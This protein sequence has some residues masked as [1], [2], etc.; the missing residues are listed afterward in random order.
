[1]GTTKNFATRSRLLSVIENT[2]D[3]IVI[4]DQ[5]GK[6]IFWN[7]ASSKIF[8]YGMKEALDKDLTLIMPKEMHSLHEAG[9]HHYLATGEKKL[10][11]Q[12]VSIDAQKKDGSIFPIELS[13]SAWK[14]E[15]ATFVCGIIR[16]VSNRKKNEQEI[17]DLRGIID[18]SPSCVKLVRRNGE[19]LRMNDVGL[20]LIEANDFESVNRANVYDIIHEE[21]RQRYKEFN[22]FICGGNKGSLIFK[23][24][25]LKGTVRI[26]ESFAR[27][28]RLISGEITHLAITNEITERV[29]AEKDLFEK[30][31]KLE[32]A[33]RLSVIGE[34]AAGIAHE[35]NN[36]LAVI[37]SK[38]QLLELQLN[39]LNLC[40][41]EKE[42]ILK[43]ISIIKST[44]MY[45]TDLIKNL[46]TFSSKADFNNLE[47]IRLEE[48]VQTALKL[49]Q[50]RCTDAGI[51]INLDIDKDLKLVCSAS[52]LSQVILNLMI[53]AIDAL[54]QLENKWIRIRTKVVN[55][56][57]KIIFTDSGSGIPDKITKKIM[58]PF[59]S[60]KEPGKGTGLGLSISLKY[61]EKMNGLF[62]YNPHSSNTEFVI[63]FKTFER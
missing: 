37:H 56:R 11:D 49:S 41:E 20:Y 16:D 53:N 58:Q 28:H 32:E 7:N 26:M 54:E 57:L 8:G 61:V 27:S 62:Y 51:D 23:I 33:E 19:L 6:I 55:E 31:Q 10:I 24:V 47:L 50:N 34:F 36:P 12:T 42:N 15:N 39:Q 46:N 59:Y 25:G 29:Q 22:E 63:E 43:S 21:D 44:T 4:A 38:S 40:E 45:T 14:E 52:G 17:L 13:L 60:T 35:V 18:S 2:S 30:N 3:S 5:N 9:M 48:V 1:M